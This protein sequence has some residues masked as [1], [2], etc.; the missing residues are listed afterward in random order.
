MNFYSFS[1]SSQW[2][3]QMPIMRSGFFTCTREQKYVT[4]NFSSNKQLN[5]LKIDGEG[6]PK[7]MFSYS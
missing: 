1:L 6:R 4:N 5:P 2:N 7:T 3:K